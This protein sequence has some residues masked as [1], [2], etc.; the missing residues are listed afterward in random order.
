MRSTEA[1]I[2]HWLVTESSGVVLPDDVEAPVVEVLHDAWAVDDSTFEMRIT[3]WDQLGM[4]P[5]ERA[6]KGS[7]LRIALPTDVRRAVD[8]LPEASSAEPG[9]D[10]LVHHERP[11]HAFPR[12]HPGEFPGMS[13]RV[14]PRVFPG[15]RAVFHVGHATRGRSSDTSTEPPQSRLV[16]GIGAFVATHNCDPVRVNVNTAPMPL[17]EAALRAAGRG[18]LDV[19]RGNRHDG[20]ASNTPSGSPP[21][22]HGEQRQVLIVG[23]SDT[24]AL[25]IDLQV[26]RTR[27]SWWCV[28][29]RDASAGV[30]GTPWRCVQR[31]LITESSS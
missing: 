13:P 24:W 15:E 5:I 27:R 23:S 22:R 8:A 28:Y 31:L 14:F 11:I 25:R 20:R 19:I 29:E 9:L 21:R 4:V 3:A 2:L 7:V 6:A 30:R 1:P 10:L 18:G 16:D 17:V 12:V 26:N